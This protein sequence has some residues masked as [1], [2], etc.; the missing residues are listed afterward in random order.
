MK[1]GTPAS[2]AP[3]AGVD[4][5][6]VTPFMSE[7]GT[8][9]VVPAANSGLPARGVRLLTVAP[10][11][12]LVYFGSTFRLPVNCV[13]HGGTPLPNQS[14]LLPLALVQ[15]EVASTYGSV[16]VICAELLDALV[17]TPNSNPPE[18]L[19]NARLPQSYRL[20]L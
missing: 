14:L 9:E 13:A 16:L 15:D 17:G 11:V 1:V 2:K 18:M 8:V 19:A 6:R 4:R 5:E 12:T 20:L 7:T 10:D 3:I